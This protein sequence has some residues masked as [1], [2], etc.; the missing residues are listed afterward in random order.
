[1]RLELGH[2]L[3]GP[4][5]ELE[6]VDRP[7]GLEQHGGDQRHRQHRHQAR[8]LRHHVGG[9]PADDLEAAVLVETAQ[10]AA[11]RSASQ[12]RAETSRPKFTQA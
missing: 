11:V 9:Q 8:H 7:L 6:L 5:L 3:A 12:S 1:M 10:V 4:H 2:Q